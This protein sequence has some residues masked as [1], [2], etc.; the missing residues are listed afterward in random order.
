MFCPAAHTFE[1]C[2][3]AADQI[4]FAWILVGDTWVGPFNPKNPTSKDMHRRFDPGESH[5]ATVC[6]RRNR[7]IGKIDGVEVTSHDTTDFHEMSVN[8]NNAMDNR[9]NVGLF[10]DSAE[11]I[12]AITVTEIT[13][14]SITA[15]VATASPASALAPS[16][17]T[18]PSVASVPNAQHAPITAANDI[19]FPNELSLAHVD[20]QGVI[21]TNQVVELHLRNTVG[22]NF[23]VG[24]E[25]YLDSDQ[26]KVFGGVALWV[27]EK[28]P[29][30][31]YDLTGKYIGAK[32]VLL[33]G[34]M[35]AGISEPIPFKLPD[36]QWIPFRFD[37]SDTA[38]TAKLGDQ[39]AT[40]NGPLTTSG[41]NAFYL[42]PGAKL[43]GLHIEVEDSK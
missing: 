33:N 35:L 19:F 22:R 31:R 34:Q 26:N 32:R 24:G 27:R 3:R 38:I 29:T 20:A 7:M 36:H 10:I 4:A 43:R 9:P 14:P 40:L 16:A 23:V 15:P 2:V 8:G 39:S 11:E 30:H 42:C 21:T 28:N 37:I 6:V 1:F 13:G 18:S 5:T 12:D 17:P 41:E 25:M